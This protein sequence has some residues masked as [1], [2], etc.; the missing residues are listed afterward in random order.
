MKVLQNICYDDVEN[1]ASHFDENG[2][3]YCKDVSKLHPRLRAILEP[4]NI[5]S[6]LQCA[7]YDN[8]IFWGYVGFDDCRENRYWI[9]EQINT[10]SF[11]AEILSIFLL[12]D[13]AKSKLDKTIDMMQTI[14]NHQGLMTY[15]VDKNY[16]LIY[17]NAQT[18]TAVPDAR[19][20]K[21]CYHEFFDNDRRCD[22]CPIN[23]TNARNTSMEIFNPKLCLW[24]QVEYYPIRWIDDGDGWVI[25]CHDISRYKNSDL[26]TFPL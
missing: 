18:E 10:L 16:Q 2:I 21:Y 22:F 3:F 19:L 4:Q 23:Q 17:M 20:G 1:Y 12:K 13:R 6:M 15:V 8:G 26:N 9:Q 7:I 5:K 11:I 24:V 25:S 14:L